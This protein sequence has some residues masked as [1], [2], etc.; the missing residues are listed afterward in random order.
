MQLRRQVID[1]YLSARA[2]AIMDTIAEQ[3]PLTNVIDFELEVAPS[4]ELP[5]PIAGDGVFVKEAAGGEIPAG[6]LVSFYPGSVYLPHEVRWLGGIGPTL[7]RAGQH[8][9]SH[10]IG[11]FGGVRIDGLWSSIEVPRAD[12]DLDEAAFSAAANARVEAEGVDSDVG[13]QAVQDDLKAFCAGLIDERRIKGATVICPDHGGVASQV[14]SVNPLA[15]GEMINHPPYGRAANVVGWPVNLNIFSKGDNW[16]SYARA[17]PNS[18]A[19]RP[20]GSPFPGA[21][22]PYTVVMVTA[23]A[24]KPGDELYLD[25]GCELLELADI[26]VWFT[27]APLRGNAE[28]KST[29]PAVAIRDELRAWRVQFETHNGRT[30]TRDDLAS[31]RVASALFETFQKYRKLGDL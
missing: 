30:P 21:P 1:Q 9:S 4:R 12:F 3:R 8:T 22:C 17:A 29:S 23:T 24:V 5:Q 19:L 14:R 31:D 25:Y 20:E 2:E 7:E 27:P 10:I 13:R 18:Y 11:R 15:V 6:T 26:P 16:A 28:E